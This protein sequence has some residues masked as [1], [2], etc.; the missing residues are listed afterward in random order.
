MLSTMLVSGAVKAA[1]VLLIALVAYTAL[2]RASAAV[3]RALLV[4][5]LGAAVVVPIVAAIGPS[6]HMRAPVALHVLAHESELEGIAAS[7]P[8]VPSSPAASPTPAATGGIS[9]ST[10]LVIAW[11]AGVAA[12]LARA[13]ASQLHARHLARTGEPFVP[14]AALAAAM[15]EAG[16]E[17]ADRGVAPK[18]GARLSIAIRICDGLDSPA[19]TG[20]IHSTMLLPRGAESWT[21]ERLRLVLVH[22]LA[23]VRRRDGLAQLVADAACALHWFDPL[24]WLAAARLRVEREL[25]ADDAV[26][27]AGVRASSYAEELLAVAGTS[28]VGALAMAERTTIGARVVAILAA[29]RARG[30]LA[31]RGTAMLVAGSLAVAVAVACASPDAP[32]KM[33]S[34][35]PVAQAA[36][37]DVL[38]A[39]AKDWSADAAVVLVLDPATGE[40]LADAGRVGD[41]PFDVARSRAIAPGST[42]KP[43]TIAAALDTGAITTTQLFDSGPKPRAYAS[44]EIRDASPNGQL[45]AAHVLAVSSNIG[46]SHIFDALG[47]DKLATYLTRFH[48]DAPPAMATGSREGAEVAMGEA[49]AATPLQM[50]AA[51][52]ALAS[53]GVYHA[54]TTSHT[55]SPG[56]SLVSPATARQVMAMLDTAVTDPSATGKRAH[57]DGVHVAGKTGT[58]D[59][60][61]TDGH[62]HTYASFIGIADLPGRRVVALVGIETQRGNISGGSSAAPAFA[63]LIERLR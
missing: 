39:I 38:A 20:I 63:K 37:D 45:D 12:M 48:F 5:A 40:I 10:I 34:T 22:E 26:L 11:L 21:L 9:L 8:A 3:R 46:T 29:R 44:G 18:G 32:A 2:S 42:L 53:D 51:Y 27:A 4:T 59:L 13:I 7:G 23:H 36:A 33:E 28:T 6:W 58:A 41:Q 55:A 35:D 49:T 15:R 57:V 24:V 47:G 30:P 16:V 62:A 50:A 19:V 54:P 31:A 14:S 25:A 52:A 1:A 61:T 60:G 56:E 43:I 17:I